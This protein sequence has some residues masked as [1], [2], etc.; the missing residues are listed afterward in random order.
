MIY[1]RNFENKIGFDEIRA[2]LRSFCLSPMGKERVDAMEFSVDAKEIRVLLEQVREYAHLLTEQQ[3]FALGSFFDCRMALQRIRL[4]GTHL[5]EDELFDLRRSLD[6]IITLVKALSHNDQEDAERE[7]SEE[8]GWK[9]EPKYDYP[10][11][12]RLTEGIITFPALIQR[13]DQILDQHGKIRDTASPELYDIRRELARTE[14]TISKTLYGIL[15]KAQSEGLVEKD[16]TPTLRDGRLVIPVAPGLKRRIPGIIHDES[17]SGRTVFIEPAVVVEANNRIRELESDERHE[18]IRIL[19]EFTKQVRPHAMEILF[20]YHILADIDFIQSKT[21]LAEKMKAIVPEI[22]QE[23]L[24]DWIRAFHPLLTESLMKQGKQMVPLDITLSAEKHILIISGPNA[25]GKSVC[26]KTVGLLQYML[27]CGLPIP[28]GERS[29]CSVFNDLMIDIGDEQS[30][31]NDLSTYSSHLLNMKNMMKQASE[32]TLIL[33]DEFGTGTEPG[34]GGA[35]AEAVLE[36]LLVKG[37]WAVITTHYQNLKHFADSHEGVAN[38]AMLYDRKEMRPLFQLSIGRPGS[39]FAI[40]IARKIGL[41]EEVIKRASDIVGQD[42]IQSDKYLQDIVRDKRYWENKRQ[43][44]HQREKD[45]EKTLQRYETDLS[46]IDQQ[47]KQILAKAKAQ[48]EELLSESNKRI[49]N[50]IREIRES[51]AEKNETKRIR[52]ELEEFK[53]GIED[54]NAKDSD[55]AINKKIQQIQQRKERRAQRKADKASRQQKAAE[56][57][58]QAALR[59]S[60]AEKAHV[61]T[62]GDAVRIKGLQSIGRIESIKGDQCTAVFGG[63]KTQLR[64]NRLEFVSNPTA[65]QPDDNEVK[66]KNETMMEGL[67]AYNISHVTRE[68]MDDRRKNFHQDIDVRGMRGDEALH[69]V[70]EFI[71]D[72]ILVGMPRVRILHGKG[73]GIL[74]ELIRLYLA[75]EPSVTHFAD[76]HVQFGGAG[77]TVVDLG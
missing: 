75:T 72:A 20:S 31:E 18:I 67:G 47:R 49:E 48:A 10:E 13:I 57:L 12:H 41:P 58:R 8:D 4:Q 63:M 61:L 19:T 69:V 52:K 60:D 40:E 3:D 53:S 23:P 6:T 5:E 66:T 27:Q 50:A 39:S 29:R 2:M 11:L 9:R 77:I 24:I 17:A 76:E 45:I 68:T 62:V 30:I 44:I 26:L 56:A 64:L 1:P 16:V 71:D 65:G 32:K 14:G 70:Q 38:G 28:V 33:I 42:Y 43:S 73:N 7:V 54:I 46:S 22:Q 51:Q 34:I 36:Q 25:G 21:R 59:P 55:D 35:L 37:T 15:R 74:R